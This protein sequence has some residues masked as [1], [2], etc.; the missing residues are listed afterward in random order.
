[1]NV[2]EKLKLFCKRLETLL[3][4]EKT[5]VNS[6]PHNSRLLT[7]LE[8]KAF[9]KIVGKGEN[10]G[11]QHFLLFPQFFTPIQK[12][13]SVLKLHLFYHLQMLSI[14]ASRKSCLQRVNPLPD[15]K[16]LV[17]SKLKQIADDI[18]KCI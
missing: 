6:F 15:N 1:M 8:K 7:S 14:W 4:K 16:I 13:I 10:A 18:L 2:T 5:L 3:E 9:E 17:W 11:N 12:R